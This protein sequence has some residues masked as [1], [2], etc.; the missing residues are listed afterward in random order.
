MVL[1]LWEGKRSEDFTGDMAENSLEVSIDRDE[2]GRSGRGRDG[3]LRTCHGIAGVD[4]LHVCHFVLDAC[5]E[6]VCVR[7]TDGLDC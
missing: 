6:V 1:R 3:S 4:L 2:E 7:E 5:A